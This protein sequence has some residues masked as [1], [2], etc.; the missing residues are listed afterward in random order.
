MLHILIL[1]E[2]I[3]NAERAKQTPQMQENTKPQEIKEDEKIE[4][5]DK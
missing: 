2:K 3:E 1:K 5:K 4:I